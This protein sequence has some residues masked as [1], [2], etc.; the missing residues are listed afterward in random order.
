[1]YELEVNVCGKEVG[2]F[3]REKKKFYLTE[4]SDPTATYI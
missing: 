1:M 4:E 2:V 3:A